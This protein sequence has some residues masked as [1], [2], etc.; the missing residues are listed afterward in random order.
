ME[1]AAASVDEH[2]LEATGVVVVDG[3][4]IEITRGERDPDVLAQ[5]HLDGGVIARGIGLAHA[6]AGRPAPDACVGEGLR[7]H[8]EL[9]ER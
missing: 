8:V 6:L 5:W 9:D 2:R 4:P 3:Q 1:P 7:A